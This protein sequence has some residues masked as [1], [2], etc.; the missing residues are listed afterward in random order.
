[1]ILSFSSEMERN[2]FW[3][4]SK[5]IDLMV[6]M[7]LLKNYFDAATIL[8]DAKITV[9]RKIGNKINRMQEIKLKQRKISQCDLIF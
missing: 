6:Y 5:F 1:M 9:I 7:F 4:T 8:V 2:I 3:L